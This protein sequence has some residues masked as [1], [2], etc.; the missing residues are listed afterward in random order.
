MYKKIRRVVVIL[1]VPVYS[2]GSYIY[3]SIFLG[4]QLNEIRTSGDKVREKTAEIKR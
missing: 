4:L 2:F 3:L 1:L